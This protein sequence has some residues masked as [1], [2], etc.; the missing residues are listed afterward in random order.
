M[1]KPAPASKPVK[2]SQASFSALMTPEHQNFFGFVFG[3]TIVSMMDQLAYVCARKHAGTECITISI[4]HVE[5][6]ETIG[7][8]ELVT[9]VG[10]VNFAGKTSMEVGIQVL[11]EDPQSNQMRHVAT[12]YITMVAVDQELRPKIVPALLPHTTDEKRRYK[13]GEKRYLARKK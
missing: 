13:E 4:D 5:F 6:I 3:G 7:I 11:A 12:G 10:S 2:A 9:M 1:K 8:G